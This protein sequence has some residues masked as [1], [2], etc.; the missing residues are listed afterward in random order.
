M[1]ALYIINYFVSHTM[2]TSIQRA[3]LAIT[4]FIPFLASAQTIEEITD[5]FWNQSSCRELTQE[6]RTAMT[7]MQSHADTFTHTQFN[8]YLSAP[9]GSEKERIIGQTEL[10]KFYNMAL[11]KLLAEIPVT[12]VKKG[13]V[14][15]W[16]LYNMGYVVK[17]KT[18]CFGVDLYHKYAER[19][20]PMIDFLLITHKHGDHYDKDLVAEME[21][22]GKAVYSNFL[23]NG[24]LVTTGDSFNIGNI[25]IKVTTVD[26]NAT[27]K[28]F[29]NTYEVN[30]YASKKKDYVMFFS[31][32]A[33]NYTQLNPTGKVD[34]F[35]PHLAVGLNMAEAVKKINPTEVL[36]SQILELG[37]A[38]TK[39][40]WSYEYGIN[41]CEKLQ[42]PGVYLPVWGEKIVLKR[43]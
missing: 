21:R 14:A 30:C 2:K 33:H 37:H 1:L 22:L 8:E 26:H 20:V 35:V 25:S 17:T 24:H 15:V 10:M 18:Q 23:D 36:M 40:R 5:V 12:K 41:E 27:L 32:D 34:V 3:L 29:V 11:D 13:E 7:K 31:G 4:L 16:Q 38:I 39:W 6:R 9:L 43:E 42:R 19:L 28:N